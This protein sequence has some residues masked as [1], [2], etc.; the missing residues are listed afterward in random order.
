MLLQ[1]RTEEFYRKL[2]PELSRFSPG[3]RFY[4]TREL[5]RRFKISYRVVA[6]VAE[7]ME[8]EGLLVR[9][10]RSGLYVHSATPSRSVA[11]FYVDWPNQHVRR[12]VQLLK[13]A[14]KQLGNYQFS[15]LSYRYQDNLLTQIKSCTADL[16]VLACP[17]REFSDEEL[18]LLIRNKT[19]IVVSDRD[20]RGISLNC[21]YLNAAYAAPMA[22]TL[23]RRHNHP[24]LGVL[25]AEPPS[26]G[27]LMLYQNFLD[28]VPFRGCN[29]VP[30][31]CH[32]E[33][34]DYSAERAYEAMTA[35]LERF[36]LN[37]TALFIISGGAASGVLR[38]FYEHEIKVPEQVNIIAFG[39]PEETRF[40]T[41]PI[42]T[43]ADDENEM[44]RRKAAAIDHY[45]RSPEKIPFCVESKP[46]LYDHRK[47]T[48]QPA[49]GVLQ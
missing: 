49:K 12:Q 40:L 3:E 32:T 9:R 22:L 28:A 4:S 6:A 31:A 25:L 34:G 24:R 21:F 8:A 27:A 17:S 15:A 41:P 20:L 29:A 43:I 5:V 19:N 23:Y 26:G 33:D 45:L 35:H 1:A 47:V 10:L 48:H 16:I 13:A 46:V 42:P 44:A 36:G 14:L 11:F 2:V 7:R 30:I 38:A 37:F 18:I 39:N